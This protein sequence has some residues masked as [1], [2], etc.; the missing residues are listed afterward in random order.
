MASRVRWDIDSVAQV[1]GSL[2]STH[3]A[4]GSTQLGEAVN[5]ASTMFDMSDRYFAVVH[6]TST[7]TGSS[8]RAYT[9][10]VRAA[11]ASG[12]TYS[13]ANVAAGAGAVLTPSS[14]PSTAPESEVALLSF[15]PKPTHTFIKI[16]CVG[17]GAGTARVTG[18]VVGVPASL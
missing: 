18:S 9:F 12:G 6:V 7:S 10:T 13:T 5:L 2:N 1:A 11:T 15:L 8:T 16:G 3:G 4:A 17:A 14:A